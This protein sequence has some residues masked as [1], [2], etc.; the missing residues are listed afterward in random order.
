MKSTM[1]E[2]NPEYSSAQED[3]KDYYPEWYHDASNITAALHATKP[4][5]LHH[6]A[7]E[8]KGFILHGKFSVYQGSGYVA[9]LPEEKDD[10]LEMLNSLRHADWLTL[11]TR[12]V[13]VEFTIYNANEN[14]FNHAMLLVETP[15]TGGGLL[16][17]QVKTFRVYNTVGPQAKLTAL[18]ELVCLVLFLCFSFGAI[19]RAVQ[20]KRI[21]FREVGHWIE[22]IHIILGL[23]V[24]AQFIARLVLT[25]EAVD[26][27]FKAKGTYV[28]RYKTIKLSVG[29][30]SVKLLDATGVSFL[31]SYSR[32]LKTEKR[33]RTTGMN[34]MAV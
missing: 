25:N 26:N 21:F 18:A 30:H 32:F 7:P 17:F 4:A 6:S 20:R 8:L 23:V 14:L 12:A 15:A 2:C 34:A 28:I 9:D 1:V 10:A 22:I 13:V 33:T 16:T 31:S 29:T 27:V 19:I 24:I 5:F 3:K 11:Y